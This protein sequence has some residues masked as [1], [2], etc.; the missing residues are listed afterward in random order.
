MERL[1]N[2]EIL[3]AKAELLKSIA[4]PIRLCIVKG[5]LEQ[6]ECNVNKMQQ[7]LDIPQSTVSQHLTK[8]RDLGIIKGTRQGVEIFYRV[9]NEDVKRLVTALFAE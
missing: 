9:V 6:G 5:L 2:L 8:L 7:C 1:E 3:T 4:H